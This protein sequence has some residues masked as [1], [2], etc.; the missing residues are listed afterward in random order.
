MTE[1]KPAKPKIEDFINELLDGEA[2]AN[3]LDFVAWLRGKK[4]GISATSN[5]NSWKATFKGKTVCRILQM[6]KDWWCVENYPY[7]VLQKND[8][9]TAKIEK[10]IVEEDMRDV[11]WTYMTANKCRRCV[12]KS[13]AKIAGENPD[14]FTG[15]TVDLF[16]RKFNDLCKYNAYF[17]NPDTR[18]VECMKK[19]CVLKKQN[20]TDNASRAT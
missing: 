7:V 1:S 11:I 14:S 6:R 9:L 15:F 16:G 2:R 20:I 3:A 8:I 17:Y 10:L 13:C 5:G 12:P 4:M 18:A 19:I